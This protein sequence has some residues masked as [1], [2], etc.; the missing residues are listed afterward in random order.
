MATKKVM[1]AS[2]SMSHQLTLLQIQGP[3]SLFT[4]LVVYWSFLLTVSLTRRHFLQSIPSTT[5]LYLSAITMDWEKRKEA[6][7]T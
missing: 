6:H 2:H 1:P 4:L 7:F 5:P 3:I